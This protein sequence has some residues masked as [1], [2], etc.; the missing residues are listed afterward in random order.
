MPVTWERHEKSLDDPALCEQLPVRD[1][2][3]NVMVRTNGALVAGYQIRGITSYFASDEER[4]RSK[5]MLGALLKSI[6]EQSMRVQV[7]Y[8]VVEDLGN[9]L[10]LYTAQDRSDLEVGRTLDATRLA[11]WRAKAEAGYYLRPLLHV[12]FIWNPHIHHRVTGSSSRRRFNLSLSA[13]VAIARSRK[14]HEELLAEFESLLVGVEATMQAAELRPR[15]LTDQELFLEAKRALNPLDPDTRGY[16]PGDNHIEYRSARQQLANTSIV[17]ETDSYLNLNGLLYSLV[18]LKELPDATFPGILRELA[19]LDFPIVVHAQLTIPDQT[20]VLK[21]YKTRLRKMQAAQRDIHG[22]FRV[23]VEAQVAESQLFRVQQEIIASSIKTVKLSLVMVTRTSKP[24][25]TR[26]EFEEAE[27]LINNRR[28]QLLYTVARMNGAKAVTETLAKRRLFLSSLPG[29]ADADKREQD[30][31]TT[32]AADLLPVEVPWL[33]TPRSPLF[34]LE[35]PYRQLIPF[36]PFD[37]SF[38]DANV[39]I[40]AKSGGGKTFMV[41]QLLSMAS[42]ANPLVSI[43]ERGD[44]YHPLVELMGGRMITMSLDTEQTINPWDLPKDEKQPARD[45]VAF[46]K[47]LTRHMLG[48]RSA[49]DTELL[50]NLI[51][52]AILRT[53]KRAAIRSSNPIPTFADLRD[54][55]SQWRDEEKNQRVMDEAHLAAIKLRSWTGEKGIY[56][57]LFDRPTTISLDNP[58]LFFN[59]EQ[60]ADDARLETAMSLLIAHA[61]A[62]RTSG[63][64]GQQSITVLDECWF[65]LDSPVLAPEVVQL[66][67]TARKRNASVWGVSQTAE[68]FV[69]SE[70]KPKV[71]GAG[72]V[73]NSSTKIVGQQ[74]GDVTAL[75]E[76][77]H[78]NPTALHQIKQFSAPRKGRSAD[79]LMVIGEKAETTHTVRMV[80]TPVDYWITTTYARERLYRA[81]WLRQHKSIP[82]IEAYQELARTFPFGLADVG[83][84]PEE[85]SM[86]VA[87]GAQK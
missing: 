14:E 13:N 17:D 57:R 68:D 60:L 24:A 2:L 85:Q 4:D 76:H 27:R 75:R 70:S 1:Y 51:T 5:V 73:K 29:M 15:R 47:N 81:W 59:V 78:L 45:Q 53:Y 19:A 31:L 74:P 6:P 80:P 23:N 49:E 36:S 21:G 37:P 54:E 50:D 43:I 3:D 64:T 41:Q 72:I 82:L 71:H 25:I 16:T 66:F 63:K 9:L 34:L 33:G 84:L 44:S 65:L 7:R 30:M 58:W 10:D 11:A 79:A 87:K 26:Y 18:S 67:R 32:N 56:S 46:L 48:D 86:A 62:Q 38:S 28:Q 61:T 40:M 39:L 22:G 55:L 69:G 83:P 12:Y 42:R 35:T 20:K 8:E 77:L 52:E